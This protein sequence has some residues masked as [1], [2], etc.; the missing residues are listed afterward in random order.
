M[1][2]TIENRK[3]VKMQLNE[4]DIFQIKDTAEL[5]S[6]GHTESRIEKWGLWTLP[7]RLKKVTEMRHV[8][9]VSLNE[10]LERSLHEA[11]KVKPGLAKRPQDVRHAR[12]VGNLPK[13]TGKREWNQFKRKKCVAVNKAERS[14]RSEEHFD[15]RHGDTE[16][17]VC[18]AGFWS[19]FGSVFPYY[20]PFPVFWNGNAYPVP[21][22]IGSM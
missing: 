20:A 8:S 3:L 21:L 7:L 16:F 19:R 22:H 4:G 11:M 6:F 15:I 17:G 13:K 14:W 5:G 2:E 1:K 12:A 10:G 9:E 18:P